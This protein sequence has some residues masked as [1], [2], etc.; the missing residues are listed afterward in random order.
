[1]K[2]RIAWLDI[3]KAL[4]MFFIYV[5][6]FVSAA[7]RLYPFVVIFHVPMFFFLSGCSEWLSKPVSFKN[8]LIKSVKSLFIPLFLFSFASMAINYV[9]CLLTGNPFDGLSAL[10]HI[11]CGNIR[12]HFYAA[13]LWFLSCLFVIKLMFYFLRRYLKL[14][15]V[16]LIICLLLY[17]ASNTLLPHFPVLAP[18]W[19]YN[20]DSALYYIVYFCLGYCLMEPLQKLLSP[21]SD[22]KLL[23]VITYI[24]FAVL[25]V[26]AVLLFFGTNLLAFL[27]IPGKLSMIYNL[28]IPMVLTFWVIL[29]SHMLRKCNLLS[30]LGRDSLYLCGSE[31]IIKVCI[32]GAI[33]LLGL[34]EPISTPLCTVGYTLFIMIVC[35]IIVV[36]IERFIFRMIKIA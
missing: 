27:Y 1:M 21:A 28:I 26:Y 12:V 32:G 6:H 8:Y 13:S 14:R 25:S 3:A 18:S 7:G 20:V 30:M 24:L 22:S 2:S 35:W 17:I 15:P 10:H 34:Q 23:P 5:G 29:L 9:Y 11:F 36:P 16:L 4:G 33:G 31:Y 19:I